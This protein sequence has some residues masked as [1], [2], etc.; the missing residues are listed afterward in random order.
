MAA[1]FMGF[2]SL[3]GDFFITD[4]KEIFELFE[5]QKDAGYSWHYTGTQKPPP[6]TKYFSLKTVSG[7]EIVLFQLKRDENSSETASF[8]E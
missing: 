2:L 8:D 6:K 5:K 3:F 7:E 1:V 4:S